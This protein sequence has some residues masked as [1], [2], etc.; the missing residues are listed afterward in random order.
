MLFGYVIL[1]HNFVEKILSK[2]YSRERRPSVIAVYREIIERCSR[3]KERS[4]KI[5]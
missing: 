1:A 4:L 3:V 5:E 2:L